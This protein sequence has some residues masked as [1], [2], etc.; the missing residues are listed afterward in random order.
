M[1]IENIEKRIRL[2]TII[3]LGAIVSSI[4]IS[5]SVLKHSK[6][7]IKEHKENVYVLLED[8]IVSGKRTGFENI[9]KL[10]YKS[11]IDNFHQLFFT[12]TPDQEYIEHNISKALY[13]I[14][15]SGIQEYNNLKEKGFY[16]QVL[17]ASA[18]ITL[19][20]DSI[21]ID[22]ENDRFTYYGKQKIDK[23]SSST[24]RSLITEG[25]LKSVP[26]SVN[27]PHGLLISSWRT[28]ENKNL[29]KVSKSIL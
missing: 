13:L 23:T 10:E 19:L 22:H 9:K 15:E 28:T 12:I 4:V 27:I 7:Q 6:E 29:Q 20:T 24:V 1:I 2:A 21:Y 3:S 8:T 17:S 25:A 18:V 26:R 5:V 16:M 11:H 14:D